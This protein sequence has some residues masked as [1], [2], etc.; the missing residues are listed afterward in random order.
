M[1][2][3]PLLAISGYSGTG[4]TT[5]LKKLIP[6]LLKKNIRPGVI[7][8]THHNIDIDKPGKD[9]YELRQVGAIQTMLACD[10]R[11]ALMTET[12]FSSDFDYLANQFDPEKIDIL[13]VEGFKQE[14]INKIAVYRQAINRPVNSLLDN[15][16]IAL[17]CDQPENVDIKQFNINDINAIVDFI[18]TWLNQQQCQK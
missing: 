3:I 13:L 2:K 5:L 14:P 6:C 1:N 4:K 7:K 16:V 17:V 10:N 12:T 11:W 15:Y 18:I 9:S 8:H